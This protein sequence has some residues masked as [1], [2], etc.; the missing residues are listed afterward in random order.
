MKNHFSTILKITTGLLLIVGFSSNIFAQ[1]EEEGGKVKDLRP[2]RNTFESIILIDNQTVDVPIKGTFEWDILHRFGTVNKGFDDLFGF[3]APSNI[4]LGFYYVPVNNLMVGFGLT[5]TNL[6]WDLNAKYAIL[7]QARSGGMP[8]SLTYFASMGIDS[9]AAKNFVKST[10]RLSYFHQ[11]ML[12]RKFN[13]KLSI[14]LS[15]SFAHMNVVPAFKENN[16]VFNEYEHDNFG[17]SLIAKYKVGEWVNLIF[18]YDRTLTKHLTLD[19]KPNIAFG[20]ELTSSAHQFQIFAGNYYGIIPQRNLLFNRND[21][22]EG[23]FLIGFN[24]TRIWNF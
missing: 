23:N 10:D 5:K 7:R 18:N 20:V 3:Y 17:L 21:P 6:T 8:V 9:R 14:Q 24:M 4:R 15:G 16:E 12:G 13:D 22:G 19:P 11:L 2:V 1:D